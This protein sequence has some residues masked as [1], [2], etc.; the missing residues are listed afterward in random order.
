MMIKPTH[1]K[2][3]Y[4][5]NP[6]MRDENGQLNQVDTELAMK[7]W[8]DLGSCFKSYGLNVDV[9]D[10]A[11]GFPDMVFCANQCF[12]YF[13]GDQTC[14]VMSKMHSEH[15]QGEVEHVENWAKSQG[16]P[17][18]HLK[19]E[20]NFEGMGD[21][22]WNYHTGEVFG[23]YGYR[24]NQEVY[25]ELE[26]V[27]EQKVHRL[28][29]VSPHFYHLDTCLSILSADCAVYVEEAFTVQGVALLKSKFNKLIK[30][31]MNEALDNFAGNCFCHDGKNVVTQ[32]GATQTIA[33]MEKQGF[34][35]WQVETSEFM[36]SGGSVFCMKM[37][38]F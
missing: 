10:G 27:I 8:E 19:G 2:V 6:Y 25:D 5:I 34:K 18:V 38:L 32:S 17:T 20:H 21:A 14:L 3:E 29:L 1:F 9:F 31:P 30:I 11:E 13:K 7:Q 23:G 33:E 28:E 24:T 26:Q 35:V 4:E 22:L 16:M 12:P 37:A 15:R 36:K